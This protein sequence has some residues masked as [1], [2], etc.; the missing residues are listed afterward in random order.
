MSNFNNWACCSSKVLWQHVVMGCIVVDLVGCGCL[1]DLSWY[2]RLERNDV[3]LQSCPLPNHSQ[4]GAAT[5]TLRQAQET[6]GKCCYDTI[7]T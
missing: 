1:S 7:I 4:A 2:L 6:H 3:D 5:A